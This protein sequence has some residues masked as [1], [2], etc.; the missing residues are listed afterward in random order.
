LFKEGKEKYTR[1]GALRIFMLIPGGRDQRVAYSPA[2]EAGLPAGSCT[3]TVQEPTP[4]FWHLEIT[5]PASEVFQ[6][7]LS[8]IIADAARKCRAGGR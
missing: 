5:D 7:P 8:Q 1:Y 2:I 3:V 6:I 4:K